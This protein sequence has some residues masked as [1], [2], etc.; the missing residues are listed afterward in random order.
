M[1][2][3]I[4]NPK[5]E[6]ILAPLFEMQSIKEMPVS[7]RYRLICNGIERI[8]YHTDSFDYAPVVIDGDSGQ[9]DVA[10][11]VLQPF[12]DVKIRPSSYEIKPVIEADQILFHM[13]SIKKVSVE[14]DGDLK[15]PLFLLCSKRIPK[16]DDVTILFEKGKIY[17]VATLELQPDDVVYLEEGSVVLGRIHAERCDNIRILGNGV[18]CGSPWHLP[19]S[20]GSVFFIDLRWCNYVLIEGITA[21]DGPMWQIVP[22]ACDHVIIRNVNSMSRI[23]T[24]DGIDITGC[25]E[26]L[27]EDCFVRA[28]DDCICIKSGRLPDTTTVRDVKNLL[29]QRCVIWNAEPGNGIEIGYGLSCKEITNLR[30]RDCDIIHCEYEGNMGG[31]AISIHQ[32][33]SAWIHHIYYEDIRVEDVAQKLFDIKDLDCKYTWDAV[34]GRVEDIYFKNIKVLNGQFPVSLIS[35]YEMRL[36]ESRPVR[37][38]FDDINIL[39]QSCNSVLDM[40][41]VVELA[42]DIYVNGQREC[43]RN[44]F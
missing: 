6:P 13:D 24:G 9:V 35:G 25:Q 23:V 43:I 11:T 18:L 27:I 12:K 15:T 17:N 1:K 10:I 42:H 44:K 8:V 32:A 22:A 40:H 34:K 2:E 41:M 5:P 33:D 16:P 36:E 4:Y 39:G 28:A 38:Y 19:D 21:V 29:V 31:S 37:I 7:P 20:N 30:F 3:L 14:L 26:V